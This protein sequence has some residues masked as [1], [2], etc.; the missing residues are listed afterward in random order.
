MAVYRYCSVCKGK[1][2]FEQH[3]TLSI[4]ENKRVFICTTCVKCYYRPNTATNA[5]I[6]L[7][8]KNT[9]N[10]MNNLVGKKVVR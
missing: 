5:K 9:I 2:L 6:D 4:K 1:R 7:I 3:L 8:E 10:F